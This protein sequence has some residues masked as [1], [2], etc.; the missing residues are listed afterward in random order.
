MTTLQVRDA[1]DPPAIL[2]SRLDDL[3]ALPD[4]DAAESLNAWMG[5]LRRVEEV[6]AVSYGHRLVIIRHFEERSLWQHLTDPETELVFP[7]LTSWLSSGFIGCRR[8]NMEAHRDA[9]RLSDVPASHLLSVPKDNLKVL[10][11]LSTAVRNQAD[12]LEAARTMDRDA[13]EQKVEFEHPM[14]HLERRTPMKFSPG[15]SWAK[16][17]EEA[18]TWALEHDI[19]GTRDEALLKMAEVAL[20]DWQMDEEIAKEVTA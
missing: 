12:V 15:R 14:Q 11:Q 5:A 18:I 9:Q 6:C 7:T 1:P 3:L 10:T 19:A 20:N 8:V 16:T 4:A 2:S 17:I 13:F